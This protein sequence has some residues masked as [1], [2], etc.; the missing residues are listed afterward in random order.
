MKEV[1]NLREK[2][3]L[4]FNKIPVFYRWVDMTH[5]E[6]KAYQQILSFA[7]RTLKT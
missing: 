4:T 3:F 5:N 1:L 2:N 6:S 7:A